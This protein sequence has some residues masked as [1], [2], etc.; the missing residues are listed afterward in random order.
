MQ[1]DQAAWKRLTKRVGMLEDII[2]N[3]SDWNAGLYA[4]L[5]ILCKRHGSAVGADAMCAL[6]C[7]PG[8]R[9][10]VLPD[11]IPAED[12]PGYYQVALSTLVAEAK[13]EFNR[14][15]SVHQDVRKMREERLARK[16]KLVPPPS[17][18]PSNDATPEI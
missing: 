8:C 3:M 12:I 7:G 17:V 18:G 6:M 4:C 2:E 14:R 10:R 5:R 1:I 15:Q 9:P 13:E 11:G 16:G